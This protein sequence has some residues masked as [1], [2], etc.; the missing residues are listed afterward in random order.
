MMYMS[1]YCVLMGP[2][3]GLYEMI[4]FKMKNFYWD[5]YNWYQSNGL[6][7]EVVR[8][9]EIVRLLHIDM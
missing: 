3:L 8:D 1:K 9:E 6:D 4:M 7:V 5:R 2:T